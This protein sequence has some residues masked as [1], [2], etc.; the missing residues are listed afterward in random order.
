MH[1][2]DTDITDVKILTPKIFGDSRGYFFES[3]NRRVL[4]E[5]LERE[6]DFVQDNFSH[7]IQGVLRGIHYQTHNPQAKLVRV[8]S[9][10][11]YDVAVDLRRSSPTYGKWVG[12]HLSETNH[13]ML[14]VPEGF[15]HAFLVLSNEASFLYK[16]SHYYDPQS[17]RTII[18]NDPDI[19]IKWPWSEPPILSSKD[20]QGL[21]FKNA[22]TFA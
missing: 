14:W 8:V 17:E 15:G 18:W 2:T 7:S 11:V 9:G 6:V 10:E 1:I 21:A 20:A 16:V 19:A 3:Y 12:A 5:I 13:K 22:E 4:E